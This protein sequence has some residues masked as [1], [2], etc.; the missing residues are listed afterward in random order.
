MFD[1]PDAYHVE[2]SAEMEMF[3]DDRV[4]YA[5]RVWETTPRTVNL[6]GQVPSWRA[7]TTAA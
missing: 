1:D 2:L 6:W 4:E 3:Y 7:A 5:P